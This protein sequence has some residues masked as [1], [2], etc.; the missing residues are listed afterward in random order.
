MVII[1]IHFPE[2]KPKEVK[3]LKRTIDVIG[4]FKSQQLR[5]QCKGMV[6]RKRGQ[7][8]PRS[9]SLPITILKHAKIP[10][11]TTSQGFPK[12]KKIPFQP[13]QEAV[14]SRF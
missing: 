8:C 6:N 10:I 5:I 12:C 14:L 1:Q 4:S 3:T 13:Q 2:K 9:T 11:P 7:I